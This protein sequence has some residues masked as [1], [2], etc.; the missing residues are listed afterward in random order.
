[1]NRQTIASEL[2]KLARDVTAVASKK[3][4][5]DD[6]EGLHLRIIVP[7]YSNAPLG[8]YEHLA[9]PL[10]ADIKADAKM[11]GS[12]FVRSRDPI[13]KVNRDANLLVTI[14]LAN[15]HLTDEHIDEDVLKSLGYKK[16]ARE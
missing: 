11:I 1:M 10:L 12:K 4:F 5:F 13:A 6:R 9:K 8:H 16:G 2:V 15:E 7:V 14:W 3:E